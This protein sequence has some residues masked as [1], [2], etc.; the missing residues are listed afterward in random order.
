MSTKKS[1]GLA[2]L[3]AAAGKKSTTTTS[4][5]PRVSAPPNL[6]PTIA[7]WLAA[8]QAVKT[9]EAQLKSADDQIRPVA[10]RLRLEQCKQSKTVHSSIELNA[11]DHG[12]VKFVV[13]DRLDSVAADKAEDIVRAEFAGKFDEYFRVKPCI[14]ISDDLTED[15]ADAL[16]KALTKALG[17]NF[18][19][20]V[21]SKPVLAATDKFFTDVVFD[22]KVR[23]SMDR[24]QQQGVC[25]QR[26]F[27]KE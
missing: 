19:N 13:Q 12:S 17:D 20:L 16:L 15:Q 27:V 24:V 11:G 22:D 10:A 3:M 1:G 2:G 7:A 26:Q 6:G 18:A 9:A 8:K 5:T 23:Q 21:K 4:K 25:T 14:S